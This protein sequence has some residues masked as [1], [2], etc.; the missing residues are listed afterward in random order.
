MHQHTGL[1]VD[2][3]ILTVPVGLEGNWHTV[4]SLGVEVAQTV[5]HTLDDALSEH[6][7]L[8]KKGIL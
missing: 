7:R 6:M 1:N 4:P 5:T 8:K 3:V 2:V